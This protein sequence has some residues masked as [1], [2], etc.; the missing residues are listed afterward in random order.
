MP[1]R[2]QKILAAAGLGSRRKCEQ[3]IR[4]GRVTV[5]GQVIV[6]M[7]ARADPAR[8]RVE[9][10]GKPIPS[11][12]T[13]HSY[14]AL[15]KPRG[16]ASTLADAHAT[17]LISDLVDLPG[18]PML[19]PVGRL[20]IDSE[21]LILLTDDGDFIYR[22]T[23][24][25]FQ[26]EKTYLVTVRAAPTSEQ[27]ECLRAG[28]RIDD[29]SMARADRVRLVGTFPSTDTAD[30]EIV[31]HEGRNRIIRRMCS[32]IGHPVARLVR[33]RIAFLTIG[34]VPSGAWR[35]LT[36]SE[37]ERLMKGPAIAAPSAA[38][39]SADRGAATGGSRRQTVAAS[40]AGRAREG[41]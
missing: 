17:R 27:L 7:G 35:H 3:W 37:V 1:E 2:L 4:E 24:P 14:I 38:P 22:L 26:V 21:G 13:R 9:L 40:R 15:N 20:D 30:I 39:L 32:A 8:Q 5:D 25:K 16:Y 12:P 18:K 36:A 28:V 23:H 10:N 31:V 19:R 11:A 29:G 34:S 33:T 6:E 41:Q